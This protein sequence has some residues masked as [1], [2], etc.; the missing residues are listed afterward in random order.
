MRKAPLIARLAGSLGVAAFG[1]IFLIAGAGSLR[2]AGAVFLFFVIPAV[3]HLMCLVRPRIII[4]DN[5][6]LDRA[7]GI[8]VIAW[9]DIESA[10]L[11]G[12]RFIALRLAHLETY[13]ARRSILAQRNIVFGPGAS[14][15]QPFNLNLA[16]VEVEP[17]ELAERIGRESAK[18]RVATTPYRQD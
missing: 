10:R 14:S 5:G 15:L 17:G 16:E 9:S 13:V 6:V 8:G 1:V 7:L 12:S 3:R 2:V 4:D 11:T 18:R